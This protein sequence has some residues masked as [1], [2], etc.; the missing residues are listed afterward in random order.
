MEGR[1]FDRRPATLIY[2]K[3]FYSSTAG[4]GSSLLPSVSVPPSHRRAR[5][6]GGRRVE[7]SWGTLFY[8]PPSLPST[9]LDRIK[10]QSIP[11]VR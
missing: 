2:W 11:V 3:R 9:K 1:Q 4:L 5:S 7:V 10:V 6:S 8:Q